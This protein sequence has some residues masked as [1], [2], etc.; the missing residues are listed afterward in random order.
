MKGREISVL[1]IHIRCLRALC[2]FSDRHLSKSLFTKRKLKP[3]EG[4][5]LLC[6][7]AATW[8]SS[9][10]SLLCVSRGGCNAA[11]S[12]KN[13]IELLD[14]CSVCFVFHAFLVTVRSEQ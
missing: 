10:T 8:L 11:I 9:M 4:C 14:S 2:E 1:W 3:D 13:V 7:E 12:L 5:E 6:S